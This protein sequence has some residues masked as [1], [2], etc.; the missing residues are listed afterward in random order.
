MAVCVRLVRGFT[1]LSPP[2]QRIVNTLDIVEVSHCTAT[3]YTVYVIATLELQLYMRMQQVS[4]V[5]IVVA[6]ALETAQHNSMYLQYIARYTHGP[7]HILVTLHLP[8]SEP[9][10]GK[11]TER[12]RH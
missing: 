4:S 7:L 2:R 3:S 11:E 8:H 12:G 9:D 10:L 6:R 1:C 5:P